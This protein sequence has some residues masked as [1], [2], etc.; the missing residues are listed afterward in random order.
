MSCHTS[1]CSTTQSN[2]TFIRC[3]Y[4]IT[5]VEYLTKNISFFLLTKT[6]AHN[7]KC[8]PLSMP[9]CKQMWHGVSL[10][11][12]AKQNEIKVISIG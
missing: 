8:D 6:T 9:P 5:I 7:K 1:E 2:Q 4:L 10:S 3:P 11:Y 12:V